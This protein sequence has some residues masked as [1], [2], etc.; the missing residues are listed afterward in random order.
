M[1]YLGVSRGLFGGA[2][3]LPAAKF[4]GVQLLSTMPP[5]RREFLLVGSNCGQ[6]LTKV[7]QAQFRL[8]GSRLGTVKVWTKRGIFANFSLV[9]C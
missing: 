5:F 3:Q 1:D 4:R 9:F 7:F 8:L 2:F 6:F